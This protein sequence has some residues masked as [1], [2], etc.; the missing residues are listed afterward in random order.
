MSEEPG[1]PA[2]GVREDEPPDDQR[3]E[4][5]AAGPSRRILALLGDEYAQAILAAVSEEPKSAKELGEDLDVALSTVYR[6]ANQLVEHD[7]LLE[8]TRIEDD[9]SH[10]TVFEANI[11]RLDVRLRDGRFHLTLEPRES[12]ADRFTRLWEDIRE[13]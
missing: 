1:E 9:G 5:D 8:R 10:H 4:V 2:E 7:L 12:P 13:V 11:D 6:R 3:R